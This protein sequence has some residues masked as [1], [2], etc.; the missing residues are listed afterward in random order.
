MTVQNLLVYEPPSTI[1][2]VSYHL[3]QR[4]CQFLGLPIHRSSDLSSSLFNSTQN[5]HV[6]STVL[7]LKENIIHIDDL[8]RLISELSHFELEQ[9]IFAERVVRKKRVSLFTYYLIKGK[10]YNIL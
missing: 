2:P 8:Y 1:R 5:L 9:V 10:Y 3:L 6:A 4:I 7:H